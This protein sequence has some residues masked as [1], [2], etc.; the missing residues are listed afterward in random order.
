M[1]VFMHGYYMFVCLARLCMMCVS[2]MC[3]YNYIAPAA[4]AVDERSTP[5]AVDFRGVSSQSLYQW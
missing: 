3:G 5:C 4:A 2:F 1:F